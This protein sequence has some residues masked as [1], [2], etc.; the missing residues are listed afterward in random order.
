MRTGEVS[1][2]EGW[3]E[4]LGYDPQAVQ[5]SLR[6]IL[7]IM[8]PHDHHEM[9]SGLGELMRAESE[10]WQARFRLRDARDNWRLIEAVSMRV[11]ESESH[12]GDLAFGAL[13]D[14]SQLKKTNFSQTIAEAEERLAALTENP[15]ISLFE[16]TVDAQGQVCVPYVSAGACALLSIDWPT[17]ATH[18]KSVFRH[19]QADDVQGL[20]ETLRPGKTPATAVN[21]RWRVE[22]PGTGLR[23]VQ[24]TLSPGPTS[25]GV[26]P[27]YGSLIDVTAEVERETA[28]AE[29]R[30][31]AANNERKL[32]DLAL[33]DSLTGLPNRRY[34]DEE[35]IK[36]QSLSQ[37]TLVGPLAVVIRVDLDHFKNVNDTL[38]HEAGDAVLRHVAKMLT[39]NV[40]DKGF[41]ARIGGDEF[42][43]VLNTGNTVETAQSIVERIQDDI[44]VPLMFDGK[45]CRYGASFGIASTYDGGLTSGEVLSFADA[46]LYQAKQAGRN[47]LEVFDTA[48]HFSII[49]TRRLA[50]DIEA[51]LENGEF[52]PYF[53][54]QICLRTGK[55]AGLEVLA[56]WR[57][58]QQGIVTPD[59]FLPA[60][61]Q[62]RAVPL[63]DRAMIEKTT[64]LAQ[65]WKQV[66]FCPPRLSFNISADRLRDQDMVSS[67]KALRDLGVQVSFEL[68]ESILLEEQDDVVQR[69]LA[70]AREAQID[71]EIDDFGSGHASILALLEIKP[72]VL[73]V[74][75]RL[76]N[77]LDEGEGSRR[78]V[79]SVIDIAKALGMM[80]IVEGVETTN[81]FKQFQD[82]GCDYVQGFLFSG[83]LDADSVLAWAREHERSG[84]K[85]VA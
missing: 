79:R 19:L 23:Y 20:A 35:L 14:V 69:N 50:A 82:L 70:R 75:R 4:M 43:I 41:C 8:H 1:L 49:E 29:A 72:Q 28:L 32:R 76:V 57:T 45:I 37:A 56:R 60:A 13:L 17:D 5:P 52:V 36:R 39:R 27:W 65:S 21:L 46:A 11:D 81:Q 48:L 2:S 83:P 54:P 33:H 73:K 59:R 77:S 80:T 31:T 38:G 44:R 74:D 26:A 62:I 12:T 16:L 55:L 9:L 3:Y 10:V 66:G 67:T 78:L 34:F 6:S 25:H 40:H 7:E 68:L 64:S 53:Q 63:I 22:V 15:A 85:M 42:S 47:R 84:R 58:T 24:A 61:E 71:I 30:S 18:A 51:G